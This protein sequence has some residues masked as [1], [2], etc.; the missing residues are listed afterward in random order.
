[1]EVDA[2]DTV[3]EAAYASRPHAGR[4]HTCL[5]VGA[6]DGPKASSRSK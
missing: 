3:A 4:S 1:M 5:A 6:V 2:V